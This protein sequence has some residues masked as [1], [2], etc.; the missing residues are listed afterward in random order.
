MT[1]TDTAPKKRSTRRPTART[2]P[3]RV[4]EEEILA[5]LMYPQSPQRPR[6]AT[7]AA[8]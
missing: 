7:K 8:R 2:L 6:S 4:S 5:D 3:I 1:Q